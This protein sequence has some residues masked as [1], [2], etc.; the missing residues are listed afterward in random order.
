MSLNLTKLN[1]PLNLVHF[2]FPSFDH[3][4]VEVAIANIFVFSIRRA[5]T[6][7]VMAHVFLCV[8]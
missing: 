8:I 4:I 1:I 5:A 6:I 3:N 2:V 7:S